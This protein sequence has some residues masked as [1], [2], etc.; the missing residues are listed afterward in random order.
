[1]PA[2][3]GKSF[4]QDVAEVVGMLAIDHP[5]RAVVK[6]HPRLPLQSG[7]TK[8]PDFLLMIDLPHERSYYVIEC[9]DRVKNS[10][11]ILMKIQYVRSKSWWKTFVF[12]Y[13]DS[14]APEVKRSLE[15][16]G[17]MVYSLQEFKSWIGKI[18]S[19]LKLTAPRPIGSNPFPS[20]NLA[21]LEKGLPEASNSFIEP[22]RSFPSFFDGEKKDRA[23]LSDP[24]E[25]WRR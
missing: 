17:V 21:G 13:R 24:P 25:K 1:M 22:I 2:E 20:T 10:K 23:I 3:K 5:R 14:V 15:A 8:V 19:V 12:V 11:G 9:Q 7:E 16:E 18:D 6:C 4:E